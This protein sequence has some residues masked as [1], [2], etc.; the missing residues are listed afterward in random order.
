MKKSILFILSFAFILYGCASKHQV[1]FIIHDCEDLYNIES[2]SNIRLFKAKT[3]AIHGDGTFI[4][5]LNPGNNNLT[6]DEG[7]YYVECFRQVKNPDWTNE[8]DA[9][10]FF[11]I[12]GVISEYDL[13]KIYNRG[14]WTPKT[15]PTKN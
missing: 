12:N 13:C 15:M 4:T 9:Y 14:N 1:N 8:G 6:L 7:Y 10:K 3:S 11:D 2:F 5:F